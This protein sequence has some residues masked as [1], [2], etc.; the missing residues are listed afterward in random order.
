[1]PRPFL[2]ARWSNLCLI[3]YQV[4]RGL[5]ERYLPRGLE[6]EA[7]PRTPADMGVVS[8]VAFDFLDTR[9]MGIRWPGHVNFPEINLRF[10]VR[11]PGRSHAEDR[12]GVVFIREFVPRAMI[13]LIAKGLYNEPYAAAAMSSR[14][15]TAIGHVTVTHQM[16]PANG[17]PC[18]IMVKGSRPPFIPEPTSLEHWFK[19]H[20]WGFGRSRAGEAVVYEVRHPVWAVHSVVS[21]DLDFDWVGAYGQEWGFLSSTPPISVVLA[22]GSPVEVHPKRNL[23]GASAPTAS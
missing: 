22:Q 7:P 16:T 6:L 10:Y 12:R 9:V 5:L 19:E 21:F 23:K 3:S 18:R 2:T 15:A 8:L 11:Q 14:V 20:Q 4:P 17:R 1:M 13:S